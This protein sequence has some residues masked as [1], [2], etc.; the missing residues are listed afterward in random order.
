MLVLVGLF[1]HAGRLAVLP[2]IFLFLVLT[3]PAAAT[4]LDAWE[5]RCFL[6]E[7]GETKVCATELHADY[8]GQD[9]IFYFA[10]GPKG[11]V[12]FIAISQDQPFSRMTVK[13]DDQEPLETEACE[14]GM[15]FFEEKKSHLL[16]KQFRAGAEAWVEIEGKAH[17]PLF[18]RAITLKGFTSAYKLYR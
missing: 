2:L 9:Y 14:R 5:H 6:D 4:P 17:E 15:C 10:R 12:P 8:Q 11:P 3:V 18:A 7:E 13:V 1:G 16:I